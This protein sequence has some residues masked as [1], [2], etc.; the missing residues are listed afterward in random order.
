MLEKIKVI[1]MPIRPA[2]PE[3]FD[4]AICQSHQ[5]CEWMGSHPPSWPHPPICR[6]CEQTFAPKNVGYGA[7]ADRRK[8]T[9]GIALTEALLNAASIIDFEEKYYAKR[10]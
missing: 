5:K 6:Y 9:I 3:P 1:D 8:V 7:M 2:E 4:C 10:A